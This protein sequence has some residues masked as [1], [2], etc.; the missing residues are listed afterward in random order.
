ML[1]QEDA[2]IRDYRTARLH[3]MSRLFGSIEAISKIVIEKGA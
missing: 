3:C 2:T 1:K